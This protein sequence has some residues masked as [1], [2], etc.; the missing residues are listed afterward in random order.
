L[1]FLQCF[2]VVGV[3]SLSTLQQSLE[4]DLETIVVIKPKSTGRYFV[5]SAKLN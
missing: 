5:S 3:G 4:L 1:L 2:T